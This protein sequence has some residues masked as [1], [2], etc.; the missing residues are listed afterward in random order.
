[1]LVL[2]VDK[3]G[4][5]QAKALQAMPS[6]QRFAFTVVTAFAVALTLLGV[7]FA[8]CGDSTGGG[9][10]QVGNFMAQDAPVQPAS[11][12]PTGSNA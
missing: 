12:A 10:R 4:R 2:G 6:D 3:L 8:L 5:R 1:M 7:L 11:P 9:G